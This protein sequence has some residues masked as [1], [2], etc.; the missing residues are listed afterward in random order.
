VADKNDVPI[1]YIYFTSSTKTAKKLFLCMKQAT[2]AGF[3]ILFLEFQF[4]RGTLQGSC[5]SLYGSL[6]S[7]TQRKILT[8]LLTYQCANFYIMRFKSSLSCHQ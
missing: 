2:Q 5:T 7:T 8:K 4:W 3:S 6:L 1:A